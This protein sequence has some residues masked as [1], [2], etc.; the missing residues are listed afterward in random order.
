MFFNYLLVSK[1]V[2]CSLVLFFANRAWNYFDK[3]TDADSDC[4]AISK[5]GLPLVITLCL[6]C[7]LLG[8]SFALE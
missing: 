5:Y 3:I 7:F 4:G 8:L 1:A 6:C 2:L